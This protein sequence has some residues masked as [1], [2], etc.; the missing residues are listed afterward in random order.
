MQGLTELIYPQLQKGKDIVTLC[1]KTQTIVA[2]ISST[3]N[4]LDGFKDA[5]IDDIILLK[6]EILNN[7][8]NSKTNTR[9]QHSLLGYK[10]RKES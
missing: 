2:Q 5:L 1:K 8:C 4:K 10:E 7:L 6:Y 9:K 3:G